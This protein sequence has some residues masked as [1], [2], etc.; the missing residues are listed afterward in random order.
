MMR[1]ST[2]RTEPVAATEGA[3][4]ARGT[5]SLATTR[6]SRAHLVLGA[7][8][9]VVSLYSLVVHLRIKAGESSGCDISETI[10]CDAV[11][12]S[13]YG[14]WFH[15]P[16]G[17][18]GMAFFVIVLLSASAKEANAAD[19]AKAAT[20]RLAIAFAGIATSIALTY[21]S[22]VL[23]GAFCPICL[24]THAVTLTL[25]VVSLRDFLQARKAIGTHRAT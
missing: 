11:L 7:L 23:I 15:V 3:I 10:N 20:W 8:G 24:A 13:Q 17:V 4:P 6:I 9:F 14:T 5:S 16:W 18:W 21:V 12:S 19:R 1:E 22:K 25:F 2:D